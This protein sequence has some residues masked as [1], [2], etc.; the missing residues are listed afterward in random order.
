MGATD[1]V[2]VRTDRE[3]LPRLAEIG[4][5]IYPGA[6]TAAISGL[7]DLFTVANR[8]SAE[9]GGPAARALRISHWERGGESGLLERVF[10]TY[11]DG[12]EPMAAVIV[13]PSLDFEPCGDAF[14][15]HV[16]WI[17]VQHARGTVLCSIGS[18]AFLLAGAGVAQRANRH[19]S[20]DSC[21]SAGG[22]IPG[23]TR[24]PRQADHR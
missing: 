5:L 6:Q 2:G 13:P 15:S 3:G 17:A 16:R 18:G 12:D 20:L 14:A 1:R 22:A 10:D 19:H 9:R 24:R 23:D 4:L 11:D 21:G 8:L 7:T